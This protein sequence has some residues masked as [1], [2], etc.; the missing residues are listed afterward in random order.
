MNAVARDIPKNDYQVA[1]IGLA[2]SAAA[3]S[4]W[5]RRKCPA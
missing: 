5:P 4:A 2:T 3:A 1:D